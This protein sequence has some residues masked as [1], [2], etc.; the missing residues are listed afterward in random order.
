VDAVS[1]T[2]DLLEVLPDP[3]IHQASVML[4]GVRGL[5]A[6]HLPLGLTVRTGDRAAFELQLPV[7][8][9]RNIAEVV[10]PYMGVMGAQA[11]P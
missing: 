6:L 11:K 5:S 8:S 4:S 10:R 7:E 2:K 1:V 9:L 3:R